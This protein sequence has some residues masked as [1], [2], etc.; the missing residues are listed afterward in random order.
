MDTLYP[1]RGRPSGRH[2]Y[3]EYNSIF[4]RYVIEIPLSI[5]QKLVYIINVISDLMSEPQRL[6]VFQLYV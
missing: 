2:C 6:E 3:G 4:P 5:S 1:L